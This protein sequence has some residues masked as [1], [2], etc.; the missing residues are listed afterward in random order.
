MQQGVAD[1]AERTVEERAA[2]STGPDKDSPDSRLDELQEGRP[3]RPS[4]RP[5]G[6]AA[7]VV[8][9][10]G[11]RDAAT[12]ENPQTSGEATSAVHDATDRLP[13]NMHEK[14]LQSPVFT[15]LGW[16]SG[17]DADSKEDDD[18]RSREPGEQAVGPEGQQDGGKPE[19]AD[20]TE[21]ATRNGDAASPDTESHDRSSS[22]EEQSE[23]D[24]ARNEETAGAGPET[25]AVADAPNQ[26]DEIAATPEDIIP[27]S[28][29]RD[30]PRSA[31][32]RSDIELDDQRSFD[33]ADSV[34]KVG[35]D[36]EQPHW[37]GAAVDTESVVQGAGES[38]VPDGES[39]TT[40][41]DSK[42]VAEGRKESETS[43]LASNADASGGV[44]TGLEER[45]WTDPEKRRSWVE[46][47][48]ADPEHTKP[49][50]SDKPWAQYQRA[51]V[52]DVEVELQTAE[53]GS[54]IWA[55]GLEID[56]DTVVVV[57]VK[58]VTRPDRSLYEG[59]VPPRMLEV[60]LR[61]F[62]RE[63]YRYASVVQHNANPVERIRLVTS[64]DAAARFLGERA[65]RI[66]GED[67]DL[68]IQVWSEEEH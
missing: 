35:A 39:L 1:S 42:A 14:M 20:V 52:G 57:E 66:L 16:G 55:D 29:G 12:T 11:Q 32:P 60:M 67:I 63:M 19:L 41:R 62:D 15:R 23:G 68:D 38:V 10:R 7:D 33:E 50:T 28:D 61:P 54:T 4:T 46:E 24:S 18:L 53:P 51:R 25:P 36:E 48:L 47:R 6:D 31:E 2:A 21:P 3:D 34:A 13:A 49:V 59:T 45:Q 58:Y 56:P 17:D 27:D 64:T 65:R 9:Q 26:A 8:D 5:A 40:L 22:P 44:Q 30:D 43:L 37:L